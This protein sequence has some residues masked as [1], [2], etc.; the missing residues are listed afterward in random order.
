[1]R[2]RRTTHPGDA[3]IFFSQRQLFAHLARHPRPVPRIEGLVVV[4]TAEE[5][6]AHRN[7]YD[8]HLPSG[9]PRE[10]LLAPAARLRE[11]T[12]L[13]TATATQTC[14][15]T[16]TSAMRR[17]PDGAEVLPVAAGARVLGV[18]FP[19][20]YQGEWCLGWVDHERGLLPAEAVRLDPPRRHGWDA[21]GQ[22]GGSLS[23]MRAVAR[24]K[25][26][27]KEGKD[28]DGTQWLSFGKGE[29]ITNIIC[30][31]SVY[32]VRSLFDSINSSS[33]PEGEPSTNRACPG[34]AGSHQDH[35]C[36][37]GTNAKG[38]SGMFPRSHIEP[39]TLAEGATK[40]DRTS[41]SSKEKRKGLLSRISIRY[42]N[43]GSWGEGGGGTSPQASIY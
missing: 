16:P 23:G 39:G 30:E 8:L 40:S 9:P 24:W 35:W 25:F 21:R 29:V 36:W 38:K 13:P 20:R 4:T 19:E 2:L 12:G 37:W 41:I 5:L 42:L 17:P 15:P 34:N 28:K 1:M 22:R 18:E 31:L 32:S 3:T 14:R 33:K 10:G 7:C 26:A 27:T 11:L 6:S 43:G